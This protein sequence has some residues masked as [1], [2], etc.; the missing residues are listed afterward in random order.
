MSAAFLRFDPNLI[1]S[2]PR[3]ERTGLGRFR[4]CDRSSWLIPFSF[5]SAPKVGNYMQTRGEKIV[6]M[7]LDG[8]M[9]LC[10]GVGRANAGRSGGSIHHPTDEDLSVGTRVR[11][12]GDT[13]CGDL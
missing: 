2:D 5:N 1:Q 6:C 11:R 9:G 12:H 3:G 13:I 8:R 10:R 4:E 7:G